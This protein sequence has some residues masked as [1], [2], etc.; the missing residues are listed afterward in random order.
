[1]SKYTVPDAIWP[2]DNALEVPALLPEL[3]ADALDSP[4]VAW[5]SQSRQKRMFGTWH[6]YT[7]DYRYTALIKSP[8]ELVNTGCVSAVEPNFSLYDQMP[9]PVALF[10]IYQK[11]WLSR[12]WQ[13][14]NIKVFV[15]LNVSSKFR[16]YNL[17]G[18]PFG[19]QAYATRGY[20][21]RLDEIQ[22]EYELAQTH[23]AGLP[24]LFLVYGGG[25]DVEQMAQDNAW[26]WFPERA[27][28]VRMAAATAVEL[29]TYA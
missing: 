6:F 22:A 20:N 11:R 23:A 25:R 10:R 8:H 18:V 24:V 7:D 4:L 27:T 29:P 3:Q 1:M 28:A 12:Y 19:W 13:S 21:S 9:T 15:D 14:K 26:L 5:G 2:T 17:L 16:A